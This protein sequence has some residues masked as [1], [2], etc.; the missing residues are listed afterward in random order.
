MVKYKGGGRYNPWIPCKL[1]SGIAKPAEAGSH[2]C[3]S[4][5][6]EKYKERLL[7]PVAPVAQK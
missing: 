4:F 3:L 6:N 2:L 1:S 5:S 7:Q